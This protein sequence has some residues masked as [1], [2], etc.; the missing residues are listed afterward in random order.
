MKGHLESFVKKGEQ[1]E[2]H[3][4]RTRVKKLRAFFIL[5]DSAAKE[6]A[7]EQHF[8]PVRKVFKQAGEI[9]NAYINQELA[10]AQPGDSASLIRDQ[11]LL[12]K[13]AAK[14]FN[15][16][17]G[18]HLARLRRTRR[19]LSKRIVSVNNLHIS[20][21][22]RQQLKAMAAI[23]ARH[24][25]DE[26]LHNCRKQLKILIYNYQLVCPKLDLPFNGGYL[27]K[28]QTAIGDWHDNQLAIQL[29]SRA[30][31]GNSEA[32]SNLKK[33]GTRLKRALTR[34]TR[35][36]QQQATTPTALPLEQID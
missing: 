22:Y 20:L 1:E 36:F 29:F 15:A 19:K 18:Q 35:D 14:I 31:I 25:F 12:M 5:A 6:P 32:L 8:K 4:F 3:H 16:R 21:Y 27:E 33:E 2:L 24:R 34:L 9:R 23:L 30:E 26:E 28:V 10:K 13:R 11:R 17:S 7:L